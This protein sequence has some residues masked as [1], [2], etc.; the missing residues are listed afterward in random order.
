MTLSLLLLFLAFAALLAL[1]S[2]EFTLG[3]EPDPASLNVPSGVLHGHLLSDFG[4][5]GS[6]VRVLL[7]FALL[8]LLRVRFDKLDDRLDLVVGPSLPFLDFVPLGLDTSNFCIFLRFLV[9]VLLLE[10]SYTLLKMNLDSTIDFLFGCKYVSQLINLLLKLGFFL[11]VQT[12][13]A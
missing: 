9:F 7:L 4:L 10:E 8:T 1:F 2:E 6:L 12:V 3:L 13:L 11:L 5:L